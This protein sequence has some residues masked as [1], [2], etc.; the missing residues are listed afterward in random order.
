MLD[1][2]EKNYIATRASEHTKA[3]LERFNALAEEWWNPNGKF[4]S[5]LAFNAARVDVIIAGICEHFQRNKAAQLPLSGLR[6]LDVGCGAGLIC[7]PLAKLG[8]EVTGVDGGEM[9]IAVA[10]AH[11]ESSGANITYHHALVEDLLAGNAG[12]Q[13]FDVVLNTEVIE[14]VANQNELI[15]TCANLVTSGGMLVMATLDRSLK[16]FLVAIV[17]AE[18]VLNMLPRGT[19]DW[20]Y[21]VKPSEMIDKLSVHGFKPF[22][23]KG[24]AFNP[25]VQ[26]WRVKATPNVN[27]MQMFCR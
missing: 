15:A 10:R 16:S 17:G 14:H 1:K 12:R 19:H 5:V 22:R 6:I 8:A 3:E 2:S 13:G 26:E 11:A 18:Y 9:N 21:F 20:R 4:K 27:Y 25:L 24:F 23:Q 7:E